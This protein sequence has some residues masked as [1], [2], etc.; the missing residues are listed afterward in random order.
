[1]KK[2]RKCQV[3]KPISNYNKRKDQKDGYS[4]YCKICSKQQTKSSYLKNKD[5]YSAKHKEWKKNNSDKFKSN[6]YNWRYA[7]KGIY[8]IFENGVCLYVG[9]S[10]RL[11]DRLIDHKRWIKNPYSSPKDQTNFYKQLQQHTN[12]VMGILEQTDNHKEREQFY[13]NKL[14]P[15]YNKKNG[16]KNE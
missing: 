4:L 7:I 6:Q 3:E 9:E 10:K 16:R 8:G 14:K 5:K 15:M 12:Y 2:C 13:I 1:M 11:R